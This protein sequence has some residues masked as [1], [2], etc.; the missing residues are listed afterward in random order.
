MFGV[1]FIC[2][3]QLGM[4]AFMCD[5]ETSTVLIYLH[6]IIAPRTDEKVLCLS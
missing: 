4:I 1:A 6:I 5:T 3:L 2:R